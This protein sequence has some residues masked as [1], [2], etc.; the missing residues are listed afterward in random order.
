[1]QINGLRGATANQPQY[2]QKECTLF[3][4]ATRGSNARKQ[5]EFFFTNFVE[6]SL[7]E[8]DSVNNIGRSKL[9]LGH[10]FHE[11]LQM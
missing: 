1:M 4:K 7:N 3:G 10:I 9:H 2:H 6:L 5:R 8:I 11:F